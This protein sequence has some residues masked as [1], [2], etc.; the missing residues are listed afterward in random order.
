MPDMTQLSRAELF[1]R[2]HTEGGPLVLPNAWDAASAALVER[3]GAAAV[4]TTSGAVAWSLGA[5]D[6][7][8][9]PWAELAAAVRRIA[10]TVSVPVTADCES[11]GPDPA[12]V[13]E[14]VRQVLDA[15]AVGVNLEDGGVPLRPVGEQAERIAAA[16]SAADALGVPLFVNAR[17]DVFLYKVGER[18]ERLPETVRR[19]TAY[20]EAGADGIFVPGVLA[21]A[22]LTELVERIPLPVNVLTGPGG[23]TI[24]ELAATGVRRISLG[25]ALAEAA[26]ATARRAAA[27]LL[28]TG[29]YDSLT[30]AVA[31]PD[32]QALFPG[33][34]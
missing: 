8:R 3:A 19:A 29:T 10:G 12:G 2:L 28:S 18:A 6:G 20:A 9:L 23:P 21:P 25:T 14:T 22:V 1:R 15:G 34:S 32:M 17:V 4:A 26:Y 11:G 31:Y 33:R 13:A 30:D 7:D 27:E 16:R 5:A 24:A